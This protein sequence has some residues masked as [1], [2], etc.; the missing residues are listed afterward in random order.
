VPA[1]PK[2]STATSDAAWS[3]GE[4]VKRLPA[5]ASSST[6]DDVFAWKPAGTDTTKSQ[7][8]G[9]HHFVSGDGKPGAASTKA[10]SAVIGALNGGRGGFDIPDGDRAGVYA[11]VRKHLV[12]SGVKDA[13]IP[14]LKDSGSSTTVDD[15]EALGIEPS[16]ALVADAADGDAAVDTPGDA[17]PPRR[18]H[19]PT[20]VVEGADTS[21]HRHINPGALRFR[22][23]PLPLMATDKAP[24][25]NLP[26]TDAT[27]AGAVDGLERR[28]ISGQPDGR[29][30]TYPDGANGI[31]ATGL[32]EDFDHN[33]T[34]LT[35]A[36]KAQNYQQNGVSADIFD[37]TAEFE[38]LAEDEDGW[39]TDYRETVTDGELGGFTLVPHP[40]FAGCYIVC[41]DGTGNPM[42]SPAEYLAANGGF[43]DTDTLVASAAANWTV[44]SPAVGLRTCTPCQSGG[45]VASAAPVAP[46][47]VWFTDPQ[48]DG[49]T[50][51][52]ITSEGRIYGTLAAWGTCH[53]GIS[54]ACTTP[55]RGNGYRYMLTGTV[56]CAD[57]SL[58]VTGV[59]TMGTGHA[60]TSPS[61]S[62]W[63]VK[64]HYDN[65][66]TGF[67]DVTIGEDA[68][69]IWYAGALRPEITPE[70]IRTI[71]ASG[72]SGDWR[73]IAGR[74]ELMAALSVNHPGF[75]LP[76]A[77]AAS[78][79]T[80]AL[81]AAGALNPARYRP[82]AAPAAVAA[83]TARQDATER[84]LLV[85]QA[86]RARERM[87][88]FTAA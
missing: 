47:A 20:G 85:L 1:V 4:Q 46:P 23:L 9:P 83:L 56:L 76:R 71:R 75:V 57:G 17:L 29:G 38:I 45:L 59:L 64:A 2:H 50:W 65:T 31:Y 67:A 80:V 48:L 55:P 27:Q 88:L 53:T 87:A 5:D 66:G 52:T 58:A 18:F 6:L 68:H 19:L 16:A 35:F 42:P 69:G 15:T 24:H 79:V 62:P 72:V 3:A 73:P 25:G 63:Q 60:D 13:D 41:D 30:G 34:A 10:C 22:D 61:L 84:Q 54:G 43:P 11:H 39:P 82:T 49:P 70:Q 81:V 36:R 8:K 26:T 37:V 86:E 77:V 74:H 32:W 33:P 21:D 28:D 12:D 78:G 14:E 40:A 44:H 7:W 51:V